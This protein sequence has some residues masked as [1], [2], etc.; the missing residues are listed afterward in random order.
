MLFQGRRAV[1]FFYSV[2]V[3]APT[4]H[5]AEDCS[6]SIVLVSTCG[7]HSRA[8]LSFV[9]AILLSQWIIKKKNQ[10]CIFKVYELRCSTLSLNRKIVNSTQ[11]ESFINEL[12]PKKTFFCLLPQYL[13]P[14]TLYKLGEGSNSYVLLFSATVPHLDSACLLMKWERI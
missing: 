4:Q 7:L 10:K 2:W 11:K 1:Q 6:A 5:L 14:A 13:L 9:L 12:E 8:S 3:Q